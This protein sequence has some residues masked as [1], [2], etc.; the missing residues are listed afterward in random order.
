LLQGLAR[1]GYIELYLLPDGAID[2]TIKIDPT[3]PWVAN[4]RF[5]PKG[6]PILT[7]EIPIKMY[8]WSRDKTEPVVV[9][10]EPD[11]IKEQLRKSGVRV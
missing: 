7:S 11:L 9:L 10:S 3:R 8:V 5:S 4:M 6:T 1:A 2:V